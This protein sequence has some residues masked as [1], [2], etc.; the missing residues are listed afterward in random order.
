MSKDRIGKIKEDGIYAVEAHNPVFCL[1]ERSSHYHIWKLNSDGDKMEGLMT[2]QEFGAGYYPRLCA[3][4][5]CQVIALCEDQDE[6]V[7]SD[8]NYTSGS[9]CMTWKSQSLPKNWL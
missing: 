5:E 2:G 7:V 4:T 9:L 1:V 3:N 6:V 8:I